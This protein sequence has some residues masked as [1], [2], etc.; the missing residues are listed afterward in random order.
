MHLFAIAIV[1][2]LAWLVRYRAV[3]SGG[4]WSKRWHQALFLLLF[5]PLLLLTTN[6]A[7]LYMGCHGA[8]LGIKVGFWGCIISASLILFSFG[9]L[10]KLSYQGDRSIRQLDIHRQ[11]AVGEATARIIDT[12]LPYSAQIGF[13]QS[14]LVIS[15][16]LMS[17]LDE[18]HLA[19]VI[20]HEQAHLH[21]RDTFWFFWLGWIRSFTFWLPNTEALWQELLLLRELRADRKAATEVDFLLLAESLVIVAQAPLDSPIWCANLN[22]W[23]IGDRLNER[24]DALLEETE[25]I[26][27]SRWQNWSWLCLLILPWLTILLHY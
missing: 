4:T 27:A 9:C 1:V 20:A 12:D 15:S 16:G 19:A 18:E 11:Q 23:A 22:H 8:M 17:T 7:V 10:L 13:W 14:E 3:D 2:V 26:P 6:I 5:P 21:Y 24:I 25:S